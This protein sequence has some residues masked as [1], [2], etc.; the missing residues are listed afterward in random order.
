[1]ILSIVVPVYNAER[2]LTRCLDS[3][4]NTA[5]DIEVVAVDDHSPD[6]SAEI[7]DEYAARD[8]RLTVVHL[9]ENRGL[10]GARNAGIDRAT[11]DYLWFVDADD[12]LPDGSV[13]AVV[14]TLK[15]ERPDVLVIDHQEVFPDGRIVPGAR[16][17]TTD[18]DALIRLAQSACTRIAR[19]ELLDE[20]GLRFAD[21]W[22]EDVSYSHPLIMAAGN[23]ALLDRVSYNYWQHAE[24]RTGA[25]TKTTSPRHFEVFDQ[26]ERLFAIVETRR[27]D[28]F[29]PVLFRVMIDHYLV[30]AGNDRRLP[31]RLRRSFFHRMARDWHRFRPDGGYPMPGG[32][33]KLKHRLVEYDAYW[34]WAI[35]RAGYRLSPKP[36]RTQ[37][38]TRQPT[39]PAPATL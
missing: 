1:M 29:R 28:R 26:Y 5:E 38:A 14:A 12:W 31:N 30:I 4:L 21:G 6:K 33:G 8:P 13:D 18:Q 25:I 9:A 22:Y 32:V 20:I 7:L 23:I 24:P 10:G 11:G 15:E 39:G 27:E 3:I 19:R 17:T 34:A 35:L 2:Y 37:H 16:L 36:R